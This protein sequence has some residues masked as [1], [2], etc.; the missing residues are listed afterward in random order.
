MIWVSDLRDFIFV[1]KKEIDLLF[2]VVHLK[3]NC[4]WKK[5]TKKN[6]QKLIF[7]ISAFA[8]KL[9]RRTCRGNDLPTATMH[10]C[11]HEL[12]RKTDIVEYDNLDA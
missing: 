6:P 9:L 8:D 7:Q 12:A 3:R 4:G 10:L 1:V 11:L 5:L 2:F